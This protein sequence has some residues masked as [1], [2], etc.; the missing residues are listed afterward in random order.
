ME[1]KEKVIN[2]NF[3]RYKGNLN[4]LYSDDRTVLGAVG[5]RKP[6]YN[7]AVAKN[8]ERLQ[9]EVKTNLS[10]PIRA[11]RMSEA[12]VGLDGV[13]ADIIQYYT[14]IPLY[15]YTVT[16][17]QTRAKDSPVDEARYKEVYEKMIAVVDGLSIE[18]IFPKILQM[19]MIYGIVYLYT[20]KDKN[21]ETVQTLTLPFE[22]C[23]KGFTTN[24]GTETIVFDFR[25]FD[26][27]RNRIH[28]ALGLRLGDDDFFALFPEELIKQYQVYKNDP[29]YRFQQLDPQVS[30]AI[31]F[32][33]NSMPPKIFA[34]FGIIDYE[35]IKKVE[36]A[37]SSSLLDKILVHQIPHNS[38][39]NLIFEPDE[40]AEIHA[41][42]SQAVSAIS[43][44]KIL[45]TFGNT[46]LIELQKE[47]HLEEHGVWNQAYENI[48]YNTGMNPNL[49]TSDDKDALKA[50]IKKDAAYVFKQLDIVTNF[51]NLAV[52]RL[53]NF[54]PY[55]VRINLLRMSVYDE[56]EKIEMYIKNAGFGV[57]KLEAVVSTG[58]KQKDINDKFK[59]E[60]YLNLDKILVPLQSAYTSTPGDIKNDPQEETPK[61][62]QD[63]QKSNPT[64]KPVKPNI[65]GTKE[66]D[67][68]G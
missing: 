65:K 67:T 13:Y 52:N 12:L 55:E 58:V 63:T 25:F 40:A 26:D 47:A 20:F 9:L 21:S 35:E 44:L 64:K 60:Q 43:G 11:A 36:I 39:G 29:L 14:N 50:S 8:R 46:E 59:L 42:M 33:F 3:K 19:G 41:M 32:S 5:S 49:Y 57:G 38:D 6:Y 2:S 61:G 31:S 23:R 15:R 54:T 1:E 28:S 10:E 37:R 17:S 16:P 66:V 7:A 51:Y 24:F 30:A 45:T 53:Y 22:Y 4:E 18:V 62:K 68:N 34:E 48:F 27:M 56:V